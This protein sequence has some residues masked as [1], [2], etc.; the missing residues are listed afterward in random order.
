MKYSLI[1]EFKKSLFQQYNISI[2]GILKDN[3]VKHKQLCIK[4]NGI[5]IE[6]VNPYVRF[7]N[8]LYYELDKLID[9]LEVSPYK[10]LF[11]NIYI[12]K[13]VK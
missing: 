2:V 7:V 9:W 4:F 6:L 1:I 3:P 8:L 11:M 5:G 13:M 10:T 12:I